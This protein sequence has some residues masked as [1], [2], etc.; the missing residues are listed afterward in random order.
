MDILYLFIHPS[1]ARLW[2]HFHLL[3]IMKRAA[4]NIHVPQVCLDPAFSPPLLS[5]P[6]SKPSSAGIPPGL[7]PAHH[8]SP[9]PIH[10]PPDLQKDLLEI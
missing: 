4:M 8:P 7:T 9:S 3:A 2:G 10:S 5:P 1:V 6:W